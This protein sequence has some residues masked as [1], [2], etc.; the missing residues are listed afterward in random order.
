MFIEHARKGTVRAASLQRLDAEPELKTCL[1]WAQFVK[2]QMSAKSA[3]GQLREHQ[4]EAKLMPIQRSQRKKK[5]VFLDREGNHAMSADADINK[6]LNADRACPSFNDDF[7]PFRRQYHIGAENRASQG[8]FNLSPVCC[9]PFLGVMT[10]DSC[11]SSRA[12]P[13]PCGCLY[14]V[15]YD[16]GKIRSPPLP[17][18]GTAIFAQLEEQS[19]P[20]R[21]I[22][23]RMG[24]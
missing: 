11:C 7:T 8:F 6:P 13:L 19:P 4:T 2:K 16:F 9:Q 15:F 23:P 18:G 22:L 17:S 10:Q 12:L 3:G 21:S 14:D 24:S 5:R 1:T 20:A